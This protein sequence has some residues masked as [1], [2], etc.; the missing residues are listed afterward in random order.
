MTLVADYI[1][2]QPPM[3]LIDE[4][5]SAADD[6]VC[7]AAQITRD[8]IFFDPAEG[9]VPAWVGIEYMAQAAAVWVGRHCEQLGRPIQPAFLISSRQLTA[10]VPV[11]AEGE[12]L[13]ITVIAALVEP[14]I[15]AF[16][17][18]ITIE[19]GQK[20]V[21]AIFSAYQPED[22]TDYLNKGQQNTQEAQ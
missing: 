10:E 15:V 7:V 5:I 12:A 6:R 18:S 2:H 8:N 19:S 1:P 16:R 22:V 11:F 4:I 9:G 17:G 3:R 14:P 21:E 13:R 20:L